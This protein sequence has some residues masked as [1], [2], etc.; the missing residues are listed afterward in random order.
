M[1]VEG[2]WGTVCDDQWDLHDAEVVCRELGY[3]HAIAAIK[4]PAFGP[5]NGKLKKS[6]LLSL[7]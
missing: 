5:G 3:G 1:Y 7:Y 2:E 4:A 6:F